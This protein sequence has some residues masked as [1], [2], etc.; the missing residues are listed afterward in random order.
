MILGACNP[1][2]FD[3]TQ[4]HTRSTWSTHCCH[5]KI[6]YY[7]HLNF[8]QLKDGQWMLRTNFGTYDGDVVECLFIT[9][10]TEVIDHW[11]KKKK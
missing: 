9:S 5:S 4:W 8:G 1:E 3:L 7:V 11:L 6:S 2:L 10:P